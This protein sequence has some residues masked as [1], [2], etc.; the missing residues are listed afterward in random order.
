MSAADLAERVEA[1]S[2]PDRGLDWEIFCIHQPNRLPYY[3]RSLETA[4]SAA[5]AN[6]I[7]SVRADAIIQHE[8]GLMCPRYTASIDAAMTLVPDD[9][10][11]AF[12]SVEDVFHAGLGNDDSGNAI[13]YAVAAT[14]ALALCAAALRASD[15]EP[16][17]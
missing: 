17:K 8:R 16:G 9:L 3:E 7:W 11:I 10:P 5:E 14:P 4:R 1:A 13:W 2:G 12:M 15:Q 6:G